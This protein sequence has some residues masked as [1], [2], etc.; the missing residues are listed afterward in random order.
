M[1]H[2]SAASPDDDRRAILHLDVNPE[3]LATAGSLGCSATAAR[4]DELDRPGGWDV[5]DAPR[6][7]Q[8]ILDGLGRVGAETHRPARSEEGDGRRP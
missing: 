5:V 4:A 8:A 1:E 6:S 7:A 2:R 3:R